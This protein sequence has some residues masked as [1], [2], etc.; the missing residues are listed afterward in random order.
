MVDFP[1]IPNN[2]PGTW[3][4]Q[5]LVSTTTKSYLYLYSIY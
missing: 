3:A 5:V 4:L 2:K 1:N